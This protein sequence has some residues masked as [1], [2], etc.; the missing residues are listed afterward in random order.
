MVYGGLI[1]PE[2]RAGATKSGIGLRGPQNMKTLVRD[3]ADFKAPV[4]AK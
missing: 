1:L 2:R 3:S 4:K